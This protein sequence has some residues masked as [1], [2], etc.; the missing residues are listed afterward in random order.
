MP[1]RTEVLL[2][3]LAGLV[4]GLAL[5]TFPAASSIFT[6]PHGYDLSASRYGM[7]FIP[8]VL[9][10]ILASSLGPA[11]AQR[12]TLKR[13]LQ[14]GLSA[15]FLAMTLLAFSALLQDFSGVAY[16]VL[17]AATGS[18]GFG[19]GATVM[20]L[21][22]YAAQFFPHRADRATLALN[23][24]LGA[25]TALAPLFVAIFVSLGVW[26]ILPVIV[27]IA[28]AALLLFSFRTPLKA[29][30]G[31][32]T[33][34]TGL[35]RFPLRFWLYAAAVLLYGIA[36]TLNGNWS[37]PY[38]TGER[39]VSAQGASYA[40]TAFWGM[41]T[42][43][44]VL[45]AALSAKIAARWIYAGLPILLVV[46]F[47]V[48]SRVDS[49]TSG[50]VAFGLAG[51][52]CSAFFPLCISLSGQEFP[53]LAAAMSG[54]MVAFYQA[55]Y[56]VAAFGVGPLRTFTGLSFQTIYSFGSL[57]AGAILVVSLAV[58]LRPNLESTHP[59]TKAA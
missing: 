52:G 22:T 55:G 2:V 47:Q 27:A 8:Q 4:Q 17:L 45:F 46:A 3:Y 20:A 59:K 10:A 57:L 21:N 34:A 58:A 16:G 53:R 28:L 13:V 30:V 5:V 48:V 29:S 35:K 15:N 6:S 31:D 32:A 7:M 37:G 42:I 36:E 14:A 51:L 38:L 49:Q 33:K 56:G 50:I 12:W 18:L 44:R 19:F 24:L 54:G 43:G 11:L 23:A 41:V 39:R 1:Q 26:W 40:L 9:L 25:G